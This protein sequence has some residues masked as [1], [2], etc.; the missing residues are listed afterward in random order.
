MRPVTLPFCQEEALSSIYTWTSEA[1]GNP[2]RVASLI[3]HTRRFIPSPPCW[4]SGSLAFGTLGRVRSSKCD[5][6]VDLL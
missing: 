5:G 4:G 6:N 2:E 1:I 3:A